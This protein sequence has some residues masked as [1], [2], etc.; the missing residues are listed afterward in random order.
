MY[1]FWTVAKLP[2]FKLSCKLP[3]SFLLYYWLKFWPQYDPKSVVNNICMKET[4]MFFAPD[5]K[6]LPQIN[7]LIR[8]Q[9][10]LSILQRLAAAKSNLQ[11]RLNHD[12]W[13]NLATKLLPWTVDALAW[14]VIGILC[15]ATSEK[16]EKLMQRAS[17]SRY[18]TQ[19][20]CLW[21]NSMILVWPFEHFRWTII[22]E[23][24]KI[25]KTIVEVV[26]SHECRLMF[27][28]HKSIHLEH[29]GNP[30]TSTVCGTLKKSFTIIRDRLSFSVRFAYKLL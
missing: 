7:G 17:P 11:R 3:N 8:K 29:S 27:T 20:S 4:S 14:S 10:S 28:C 18:G 1:N 15:S 30:A 12:L 9:R 24:Q 2:F 19:E 25:E 22:R 16:R 21:L 5:S 6:Q 13:P 26:P 23:G